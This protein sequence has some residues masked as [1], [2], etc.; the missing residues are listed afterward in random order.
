VVPTQY[1]DTEIIAGAEPAPS[2]E[3]SLGSFTTAGYQGG[4]FIAADGSGL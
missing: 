3:M 4:E 2:E 1:G